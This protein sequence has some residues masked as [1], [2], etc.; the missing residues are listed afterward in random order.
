[1]R[2]FKKSIYGL[3]SIFAIVIACTDLEE[4]LVSDFTEASTIPG[5]TIDIA[6]TDGSS[7]AVQDQI[8]A[9]FEKLRGGTA[10]HNNYWSVQSV[11]SDEMQVGQKGGD[12]YDGG[13]WL[14]MHK[15]E[16]TAA[17]GPL[18]NTWNTAYNSCLLYTSDAADE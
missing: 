14:D 13:I 15:H 8:G 7:Q 5:V 12:W 1:M 4:E 6:A 16:Y 18:T 10:G 9:A 17:S 2:N 11:S 3:V